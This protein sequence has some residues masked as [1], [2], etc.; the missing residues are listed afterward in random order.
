MGFFIILPEYRGHGLGRKLAIALQNMM[1]LRLKPNASIGIDGVF[2]MQ[3]F[4]KCGGF[5]F[6]HRELRFE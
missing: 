5:E 2:D 3:A 1:V 4:Y 6:S